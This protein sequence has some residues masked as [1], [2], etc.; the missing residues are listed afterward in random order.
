M[1]ECIKPLTVLFFPRKEF[2]KNRNS[3]FRVFAL[4]YLNDKPHREISKIKFKSLNM[5]MENKYGFICFL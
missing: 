3:F 4:A 1:L 5:A 2:N